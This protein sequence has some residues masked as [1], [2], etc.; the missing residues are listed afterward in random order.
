[1]AGLALNGEQKMQLH[2]LR[3][4]LEMSPYAFLPEEKRRF[5]HSLDQLSEDTVGHTSAGQDSVALQVLLSD[6]K[7]LI[8]RLG[9]NHALYRDALDALRTIAPEMAGEVEQQVEEAEKK[10]QQ[11]LKQY[12]ESR[13]ERFERR[14]NWLEE[15][16]DW[17]I[18]EDE[19]QKVQWEESF[20]AILTDTDR[21]ELTEYA[22]KKTEGMLTGED[23]VRS[24]E[25]FRIRAEER[26]Q[27]E[28]QKE[29]PDRKL[30]RRLT[31]R[32]ESMLMGWNPDDMPMLDLFSN[33][34]ACIPEGK[35]K[36]DGI[37]LLSKLMQTKINGWERRHILIDE[38]LDFCEAAGQQL[39]PDGKTD[40]GYVRAVSG[41]IRFS[42]QKISPNEYPE[43]PLFSASDPEKEK[44]RMTRMAKNAVNQV[45]GTQDFETYRKKQTE[46]MSE[47]PES[48][49]SMGKQGEDTY[50]CCF[51]GEADSVPAEAAGAK[52]LIIEA[53]TGS[54]PCRGYLDVA[55]NKY[56]TAKEL[57]RLPEG[58]YFAADGNLFR[59]SEPACLE[60]LMDQVQFSMDREGEAV[61]RIRKFAKNWFIN[62]RIREGYRNEEERDRNIE[63]L[64]R[65]QRIILASPSEKYGMRQ[66]QGAVQEY[67]K[68]MQKGEGAEEIDRYEEKLMNQCRDYMARVPEKIGNTTRRNLEVVSGLLC[69]LQREYNFRHKNKQYDQGQISFDTIN[70]KYT[71]ETADLIRLQEMLSESVTRLSRFRA[72]LQRLDKDLGNNGHKDAYIR[73]QRALADC[74]VLDSH[75]S[76]RQIDR[77]GNNLR[78]AA[79]AFGEEM[80]WN[81]MEALGKA[82]NEKERQQIALIQKMQRYGKAFSEM[83]QEQSQ[84]IRDKSCP[85][86]YLMEK[87]LREEEHSLAKEKKLCKDKQDEKT[88]EKKEMSLQ[89]PV[90]KI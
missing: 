88:A 52:R 53:G 29:K 28:L 70:N 85:V 69:G 76:I 83:I 37:L 54:E 60:D 33:I 84:K 22:K 12:L 56:Y 42:E 73:L 32:R 57:D 19:D 82:K 62:N 49:V 6:L 81:G 17:F 3:R 64:T 36:T 15:H 71:W 40:P 8:L 78:L 9:K 63:E 41:L 13:Q 20:D 45:F 11:E 90:L 26:I 80:G 30:C 44:I 46:S 48:V 10:R 18:R 51:M 67:Q 5:F 61:F 16:L 23:V 65:N 4:K 74:V 35:L 59:I 86:G 75:H 39:Y 77:A 1:M 21:V 79:L 72:P 27:E 66:L 34:I 2:K 55:H 50:V 89:C 87:K 58:V 68:I 24:R 14:V 47:D 43:D 25:N 7:R 38:M 31:V